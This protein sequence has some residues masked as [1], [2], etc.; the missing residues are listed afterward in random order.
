VAEDKALALNHWIHAHLPTRRNPAVFG[1]ERLR[2]TPV[3]VLERGGDCADKSRL[4]SAMLRELDIPATMAMLFDPDSGL[5]TH[6]VVEARLSNKVSMILDPSFELYFPDSHGRYLGLIELRQD[7]GALERRLTELKAANP[8]PAL[9][10][11]YP[12]TYA[13]YM[14]ASTIN[15]NKNALTRIAHDMLYRWKGEQLYRMARPVPLEEPKLFF[16]LAALMTAVALYG[17][18]E[19]LVLIHTRWRKPSAGPYTAAG[20]QMISD[21]WNTGPSVQQSR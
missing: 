5:P 18:Q 1:W 3:Q 16:S 17:C 15:W 11:F 4:L 13:N 19:L 6:T 9:C 12:A 21:A 7:P 20:S 2:A 10:H 8:R 14:G